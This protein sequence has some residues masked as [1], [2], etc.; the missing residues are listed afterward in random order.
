M[1]EQESL[2]F[3]LGW[4]QE[5]KKAFTVFGTGTGNTKTIT[6]I[7]DGSGKTQISFPVNALGTENL[8]VF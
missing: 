8:K 6:V 7:W 1:G 3:I 2:F 5:N 4:E